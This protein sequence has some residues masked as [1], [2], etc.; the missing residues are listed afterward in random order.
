MKKD[1]FDLKGNHSL[2][3][4]LKIKWIIISMTPVTMLLNH[5]LS[6]YPGW[7]EQY[8]SVGINKYIR[9]IL[10]DV[11]SVYPYS[12]AEILSIILGL[13]FL[14]FLMILIFK[15][16]K[17]GFLR[18]LVTLLC[19]L[20]SLYLLFMVLWGFNYN[21]VSLDRLMGLE[22]CNSNE[23]DLFVLCENLVLEANSL[24]EVVKEDH[25][26]VMMV[27]GG[28]ESVFKRAGIGYENVSQTIPQLKGEYGLPKAVLFSEIM[29]YIGICGMYMPY[30]GEANININ[31]PDLLLP[32][33]VMHEMAHQR[34][35]SP[36]DEANYIA[37]L[38]CLAHPDPDFRYSGTML[39]LIYATNALAQ[40]D[41][42]AFFTIREL[43]S[44]DVMRDLI[45]YTD[46]WK[47]YQGRTQKIAQDVNNV[48]LKTNGETE[49]I[50]SYGKMVDLLLAAY[51]QK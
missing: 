33:T 37:Y 46:F 18:Q 50:K 26:G 31:V 44:E 21:R 42:A 47:K 8:Y 39:A 3:E 11:S 23:Q 49:G 30:T 14:A 51:R 40:L 16:V 45:A 32:S 5:I 48:Y 10:S 20:S 28:Y 19:Y 7:I 27:E 24:R 17:G 25:R 13:I 38:T 4:V 22:M 36:E 15:A 35:F 43:Y 29:N 41:E 6:N 12:V 2:S 1:E 9:Q 34:G